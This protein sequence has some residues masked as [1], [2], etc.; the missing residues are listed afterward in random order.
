M[1]ADLTA[2]KHA[3]CTC[4]MTSW[5][6]SVGQAV[7]NRLCRFCCIS[8]SMTEG[9][10]VMLHT[11]TTSAVYIKHQY[12]SHGWNAD[13]NS[14][15]QHIHTHNHLMA[16]VRDYLGEPVP[17]ET[18]THSH[19]W[20]RR[21]HTD[22]K[23]HWMGAHH[24]YDALSQQGLL[25]PIRFSIQAKLAQSNNQSKQI[26]IMQIRGY[27][28]EHDGSRKKRQLRGWLFCSTEA[29]NTLHESRWNSVRNMSLPFR[30]YNEASHTVNCDYQEFCITKAYSWSDSVKC[31]ACVCGVIPVWWLWCNR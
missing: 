13:L 30:G 10:S 9:I 31:L 24:L 7:N 12:T 28:P 29:T 2:D 14:S 23:V 8:D 20:T 26:Y 17:E 27:H 11:P 3:A 5:T 22:N 25:D 6:L 16:L 1:Y 15:N 4:K 19:P 21:I 18:F